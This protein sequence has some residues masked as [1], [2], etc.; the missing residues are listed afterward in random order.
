MT[1]RACLLLAVSLTATASAQPVNVNGGFEAT[2]VGVVT[3]LANGVEGWALEANVPTAPEFAIVDDVTHSGDRALRVTVNS[4]GP[5]AY[6]VQAIARPI[7]VIPG[8]RYSFS[9]WAR[10]DSGTSEVTFT[11]GNNAFQEYGRL[12]Q[13]TVSAVWREFVFEFTVTDQET[14]IRAPIHVSFA[15]NVGDVIYFDDLEIREPAPPTLPDEPLAAGTD[16]FLGNLYSPQQ[17]P[18]FQFY[19]NQVTPENAGKWGSVEAQRDV[20]RWGELDAA[21]NLAK[22]NGLPF[23]FHVLVWGDQQPAWL[24]SLPPD[25]QLAEIREWFQAVADRYPDL[26]YVE[27]VNEPLHDPPTDQPDDPNSGG[28]IEALGGEGATGW[29]WIIT[30]FE[31]AREVFPEGTALMLNDYNILSSTQNAGHYREIVG[32][33]Q[34]RDLI[35]KIGVQG[36]AFSTRRGAPIQTVLDGLAETGLPIQ[37]TEMDVDGNPG[38]SPTLS[39]EASDEIQLTAM[40]RIFPILWEHPAVEGVTMWGWRIGHWRTEQDA[41][42]VRADGEERPAL[43]WLREYIARGVTAHEP[44]TDADAFALASRPNPFRRSAE[45]TF[46]LTEPADVSLTVFDALGRRVR[47]LASGPRGAGEHRATFE[48][49]GLAAGVYVVRLVAGER[50]RTHRIVLAR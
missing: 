5:N 7:P 45:I 31:M 15:G 41:F 25:E 49:A 14:E 1:L 10:T 9:I 16:K 43:V 29:D 3:D 18:F 24:K 44:G 32:L 36:H 22:D 40:Q 17:R 23:R 19:W 30:A 37:V 47:S 35:D 4:T 11:V 20:M 42:L 21:Y 13:E 6:D 8:T 34:E 46:E 48:P 2:D 28:Y 33:L 27:V 26:D 38:A 39:D 12:T 50:V